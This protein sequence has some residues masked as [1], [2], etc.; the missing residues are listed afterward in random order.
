MAHSQL[1]HPSPRK[2]YPQYRCA[3]VSGSD[4]KVLPYEKNGV[5]VTIFA[6]IVRD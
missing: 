3:M 5:A 2:E 4:H 6:S 1:W